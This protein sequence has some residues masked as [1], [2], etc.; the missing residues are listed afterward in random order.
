[1]E[2]IVN[3]KTVAGEVTDS[4]IEESIR[5]LTGEGDSFAILARESEVYIQTAGGPA[6]G[7]VLEYRNGSA[8]QHYSC[9]NAELAADQV[10]EAFRSYRANDDKWKSTFKWQ[11]QVFDYRSDAPSG[12]VRLALIGVV[13]VAAAA[14]VVWKLYLS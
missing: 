11:P 10:I 3:G 13:I 4:R 5:S 14:F 9:T 8:D 1:M 6:N 12:G 2:L 7:F